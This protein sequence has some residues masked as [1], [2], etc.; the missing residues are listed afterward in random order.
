M[1]IA[2]CIPRYGDTK[3]EFTVSLARMLVR[4]LSIPVGSPAGPV[5]FEIEIFSTTSYDLPASRTGLL[6]RAMA[7]QA[8]YLLWLDADHI[9]PPDALL[10]LL[11]HSLPVVGC[12]YPPPPSFLRLWSPPP[13][14]AGDT[15]PRR[16]EPT[17]PTAT[18]YNQEGELEQLWTTAEK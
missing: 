17:G 12:N 14:V 6:K 16:A 18:R 13:P 1:R 10:R 3:G 7:W 5:K 11:R 9:F 2:I 4:T 15:T 8:R